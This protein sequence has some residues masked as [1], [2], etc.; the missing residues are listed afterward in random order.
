MKKEVI[1]IKGLH[2]RSCEIVTEKS[3]LKIPGVTKAIV[4]RKKGTAEIY[5]ESNLNQSDVEKA[6]IE[7]GYQIGT[8]ELSVI[9]KDKKTYEELL[10]A[11][12]ATFIF[13]Y[14]A[15]N[16]KILSSSLGGKESYASLS[17]VLLI[18]LTAGIS[19]CM[20]LV[21]GIVLGVASKFSSDHPEANKLEK[22]KPH[23]LFNLGRVVSFFLLGGLIGFGGSIFQLPAKGMGIII[24]FV[25]L[26]MIFLGLQLIS[27][28][29]ILSKFS[30]TLPKKSAKILNIQSNNAALLGALTFFL[31][32]GFTQAMQAFSIGSQSALTGSLTMGVFALGT[33]PGLLGIG[34]LTS[35]AKGQM[36]RIFFKF[37]GLIVILLAFFNISNGLNLTGFTIINSAPKTEN[38]IP[39]N[40]NLQIVNMSQKSFGYE[41]KVLTVKKGVP[42]KWIVT[43]ETSNSCASYIV[44]PDLGIKKAL[45]LGENIFEFTPTKAGQIRFSCAMGMYTGYFNVIE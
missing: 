42:V 37:S 2:C 1:N 4:D 39:I 40:N 33:T 17:V 3:L 5:F 32:C 6:I 19:T 29:P 36:G 15:I 24:I 13:L 12:L 35:F 14:V 28:F 31:P 41:P 16:S 11:A 9:S 10:I 21:G 23:L 30:F 8:E 45:I 38:I 27:V 44:V 26:L 43:S 7:A 25:S 20:A 34:A 22:L 18:G